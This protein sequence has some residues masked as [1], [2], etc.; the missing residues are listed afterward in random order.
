M[1]PTNIA[2][3]ESVEYIT[4]ENAF[5][6]DELPKTMT[7]VGAGPIGCEIGQ[8]YSRLGVK[9]TLIANNQILPREE[10]EAGECLQRV[11]ENEGIRVINSRLTHVEKQS[12]DNIDNDDARRVYHYGY[13]I[14]LASIRRVTYMHRAAHDT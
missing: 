10:S 8:A 12:N 9:V 6:I 11:F 14:I 13:I 2:G 7:V 3:L 5:D 4:Y 1:K